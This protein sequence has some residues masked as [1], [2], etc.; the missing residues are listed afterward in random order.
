MPYPRGSHRLSGGRNYRRVVGAKSTKHASA[1]APTNS[2]APA[3]TGTATVGQTLSTTD[4]TWTGTPTSYTY[5]WQRA[6]VN[7]SSA[8]AST[9]V[10][11]GSDYASAIRCVVTATNATGSTAANSNATAA[12]AYDPTVISG[13]QGWY[14]S[15]DASS[16]TFSAGVVVSQWSDKSGLG[17]HVTQSNN[18]KRPSRNGS[19]N[20]RT[21]V[22]YANAQ[23]LHNTG[24]GTL[25]LTQPVTVV[26]AFKYANSDTSQ[27]QP[28]NL[29]GGSNIQQIYSQG[30]WRM[31]A[32]TELDSGVTDD[33]LWHTCIAVFNG[34]SSLM[35][36]D[37]TQIAA[38]NAGAANGQHITIGSYDDETQ[39][40]WNGEI[41]EVLI[42]NAAISA[43]NRTTLHQYLKAK[44]GTT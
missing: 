25:N 22:A 39:A 5:Q 4:G 1:S 35:F 16:F 43:G 26:A 18:T 34:G 15:D 32:N 11:I 41:A 31:Y 29:G 10:L 28:V 30:T 37:G 20:S 2:V 44:W 3:V 19:Q 14:D 17:N 40:F 23:D 8:T 27:H 33:A 6:G 36:L 7:I 13:M 42:F 24:L 38:G 12:V 9:Y 21:T